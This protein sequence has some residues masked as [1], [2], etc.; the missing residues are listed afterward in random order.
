MK[1]TNN[2]DSNFKQAF[3]LGI[4]QFSAFALAIVS[5]AILSRYF[6]KA[7][8][9]TYKQV[10]Y[11]YTTLQTIFTLG[12]PKVFSYFIPRL[13][14][15]QSK[16]LV[17]NLTI[18]LSVLGGGF[19]ITLYACSGLIGSLLNNPELDV[20][21]KIF[22]V[23]PL[24]TIPTMGVEGIYIAIRETKYITVFTVINKLITLLFVITPVLF[25]NGSYKSALIGWSI[26]HFITFLIALYLKNR[27]F[28]NTNPASVHGMYRTVFSYSLPLLAASFA[29]LFLHSANQFFISRY[30]GQV[31]FAEFTNGFI[32]LPFIGMIAGS[33]KSV[34]LPIFSKSDAKGNLS[35]ICTIYNNAVKQTATIIFP[36]VLFCMFNAEKIVTLLYGEQYAIS[37]IYFQISLFRDIFDVLPYLSVLMAI[38][39]SMVYL[40]FHI[41]FSILIWVVDF[42]IVWSNMPPTFIAI[43]YTSIHII[44]ILSFII[45]IQKI[46]KISLISSNLIY[47]AFKIILHTTVVLT[48]ISL[49]YQQIEHNINCVIYL[50]ICGLTFYCIII[51]TGRIIKVDYASF[52]LRSL[53]R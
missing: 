21:L 17:K 10:M 1:Y 29:G 45:Y 44:M 6:D 27:P 22:S 41:I 42:I 36:I 38:G 33:V 9:G 51:L 18:L 47:Y 39:G 53:N 49:A 26:A 4:S 35:D 12:I 8:Y 50:V 16:T 43:A 23:V 34:L 14:I 40:V 11:V 52:I 24:F 37:K 28:R 5:A 20:A 19:S 46:K 13:N 30:Y 25:F 48:I 31:V 7:E 15:G 3:W 32:T 2:S